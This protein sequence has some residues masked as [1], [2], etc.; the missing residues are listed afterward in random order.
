M[1]FH[2]ITVSETLSILHV[3][4]C[5][6]YPSF[7]FLLNNFLLYTFR[8]SLHYLF[9]YKLNFSDAFI[10]YDRIAFNV[11]Y[12]EFRVSLL[13][14][15]FRITGI[16]FLSAYMRHP[17]SFLGIRGWYKN[18]NSINSKHEP[19]HADLWIRFSFY[20]HMFSAFLVTELWTSRLLYKRLGIITSFI[21]LVITWD[22]HRINFYSFTT[23]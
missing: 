12:H 11:F 17:L 10:S 22:K 7:L 23:C 13:Y 16:S 21:D 19:F 14:V 9:I 20:S 3:L 5:T 8:A 18:R 2:F 15:S 1:L 6:L 4:L